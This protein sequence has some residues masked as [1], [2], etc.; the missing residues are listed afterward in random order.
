MAC[1][2]S[3]SHSTWSAARNS[4]ARASST[5]GPERPSRNQS[6]RVDAIAA[7][8]ARGEDPG[9][10]PA[11]LRERADAQLCYAGYLEQQRREI[12]RVRGASELPIDPDT[13]YRRLAGLTTEAAE[14]LARV[15]PTSTGQVA[16]IPGITPAALMCVWA[17]ARA[18]RRRVDASS[19]ASSEVSTEVSSEAQ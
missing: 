1:T 11:W 13:D 18:A 15:R 17:H 7:A 19:E 5:C 14:R 12:E 10:A 6:P 3:N 9:P 8:V 16:R 2:A 4:S